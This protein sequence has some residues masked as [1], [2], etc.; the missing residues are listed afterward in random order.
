MSVL[1]HFLR[2]FLACGLALLAAVGCA[3][4]Q[5]ELRPNDSIILVPRGMPD[6]EI[7]VL[8]GI[9]N[10]DGEGL[11]TGLPYLE[12]VHIR[13]VGLSNAQ[14]AQR[15][16]RAYQ[17]AQI[18]THAQFTVQTA[19]DQDAVSRTL[20][21]GGEVR[22]PGQVNYRAE[23]T[24]QAAIANVGGSTEFAASKVVVTRDGREISVDVRRPE[25]ANFLVQPN[26][27][28]EVWEQGITGPKRP[29]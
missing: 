14:L 1:L 22:A 2:S 16:T 26:D 27:Y 8:S 18:Y 9:Y 29:N 25:G 19:N 5:S 7:S 24:L 15:I 21:V 13:A 12:G 17:D 4:A 6:T 10:I 28:V 11:L 23:M 3:S 20:T